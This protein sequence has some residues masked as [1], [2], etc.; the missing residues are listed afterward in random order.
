MRQNKIVLHRDAIIAVIIITSSSQA[1][2]ENA[3]RLQ[4]L[5]IGRCIAE[6]ARSLNPNTKKKARTY[7]TTTKTGCTCKLN[8]TRESQA[9]LEGGHQ[10]GCA[11]R[12]DCS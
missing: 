7:A 8:Y 10:P 3:L 1:R 12:A 9:A 4:L 6:S 11:T 2:R 5:V